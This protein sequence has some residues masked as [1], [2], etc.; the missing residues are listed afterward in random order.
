VTLIAID[1]G[2]EQS[3]MVIL[4]TDGKPVEAH[5]AANHIILAAL[6]LRE[7]MGDMTPV[8]IEMIASYGMSVG[9]EVFDTCVWIGRFMQAAGAERCHQ[10]F[11]RDIKLH[12][13][14]TA[15]ANDS[16]IRYAICDRFGGKDAAIGRK[17]TP[18]PLY[19]IKGDCWAALALALYAHDTNRASAHN[20]RL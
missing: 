15:R 10:V 12:H 8:H 3:A 7:Q 14:H 17:K 5:K 1:P 2:S 20:E 13:C 16:A 9:K 18:G 19:G 11:R 6:F 4:A